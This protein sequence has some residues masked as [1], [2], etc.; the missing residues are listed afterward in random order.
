MKLQNA[1]V[2]KHLEDHKHITPLEALQNYGCFR[3]AARIYELRAIGHHI[4]TN[5]VNTDGKTYAQYTL[6]NKA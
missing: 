1:Q 2:L 3:L 4:I 6:I 5:H